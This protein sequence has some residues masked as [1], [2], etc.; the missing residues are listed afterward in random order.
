[1]GLVVAQIALQQDSDTI[2]QVTFFHNL[3]DDILICSF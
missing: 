2:H 1:V 3:H